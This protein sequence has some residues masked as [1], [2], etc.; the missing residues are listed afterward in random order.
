VD[1]TWTVVNGDATESFR[2]NLWFEMSLLLLT[3]TEDVS[4]LY[5]HLSRYLAAYSAPDYAAC[6]AA[7]YVTC[8]VACGDIE[9]RWW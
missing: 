9:R 3:I 8:Y 1:P 7:C 4:T 6:C 2:V 5:T